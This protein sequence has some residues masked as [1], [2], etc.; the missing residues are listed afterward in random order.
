MFAVHNSPQLYLF[1][2]CLVIHS[3]VCESNLMMTGMIGLGLV[4]ISSLPGS[5]MIVDDL[6]VWTKA[7]KMS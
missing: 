3:F 5:M 4:F 6:C 1:W 2:E 7:W